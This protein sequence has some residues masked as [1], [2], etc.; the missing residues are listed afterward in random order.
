[1]SVESAVVISELDENWPLVDDVTKEG[2]DHLRLIKQLLKTQFLGELGDGFAIPITATENEIN[3]LSGVTSNVQD[4]FDTLDAKIVG[5][6]EPGTVMPFYQA[7]APTGWTQEV[8]NDNCM[9]RI[10]SSVGG[11]V[12]GSDSPILNDKIPTHNHTASSNTTGNHHH[13]YNAWQA[14]TSYGLDNSPEA[15]RKTSDTSTSGDHSHTITVNNNSGSNWE[16]KYMD[17]IVC[18]KD[19]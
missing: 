14:G 11:G 18:S 9:M 12:G 10:V 4:Q 6:L 19:P 1:M 7:T 2:D 3:F 8:L 17:F 16:P 13:T 15:I 5:L